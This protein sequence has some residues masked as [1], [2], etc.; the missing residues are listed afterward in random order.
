M[1]SRAKCADQRCNSLPGVDGL[2]AVEHLRA[3]FPETRIIWCSE[4]D[5]PACVPAARRLLSAGADNGRSIPAWALCMGR[6]KT[7]VCFAP[8]GSQP[9]QQGGSPM[10]KRNRIYTCRQLPAGRSID[11]VDG[12]LQRSTGTGGG[13]ADASATATPAAAAAPCAEETTP[14]APGIDALP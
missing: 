4:L 5:F 3:L 6:G 2:N 13:H 14:S 8:S 1:R 7:T 11:P 9:T 12:G 10:K